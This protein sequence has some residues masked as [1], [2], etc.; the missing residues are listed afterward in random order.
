MIEIR[1]GESIFHPFGRYDLNV[2]CVEASL[3]NRVNVQDFP[4]VLGLSS[5]DFV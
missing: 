1:T 3:L 5:P 4:E 2:R